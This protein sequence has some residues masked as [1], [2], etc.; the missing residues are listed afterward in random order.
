MLIH[1]YW[2]ALLRDPGLPSDIMPQTWSGRQAA[3]L[4]AQRLHDP[5]TTGTSI[6]GKDRHRRGWRASVG[7][8]AYLSRFHGMIA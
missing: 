3:E 6:S 1:V 5:E 8:E 4:A 7:L 2:R